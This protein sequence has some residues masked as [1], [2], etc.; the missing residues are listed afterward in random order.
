MG[1]HTMKR[2][3]TKIIDF[4]IINKSTGQP[5]N[6]TGNKVYFTAKLDP[7]DLDDDA[8]ILLDSDSNGITIDSPATLGTGTVEIPPSATDD[9][10]DNTILY[11][12]LQH[13][14]A[15]GQVFTPDSGELL[16]ELDITRSII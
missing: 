13:V 12:D 15:A 10:T 7:L 9:L 5:V 3:D 11:Y 2:G 16:V 8:I 1:Y 4:A 6:L 14:T